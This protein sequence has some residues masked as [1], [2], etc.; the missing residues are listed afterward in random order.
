[1]GVPP[2]PRPNTPHPPYKRFFVSEGGV[3]RISGDV[4]FPAPTPPPAPNPTLPPSSP[5]LSTPPSPP[6]HLTPPHPT[7]LQPLSSYQEEILG[8]RVSVDVPFPPTLYAGPLEFR[9]GGGLPTVRHTND[10]GSWR[11]HPSWSQEFDPDHNKASPKQNA[12]VG[13]RATIGVRTF[14]PCFCLSP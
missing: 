8:F 13:P 6:T 4:Y 3:I 11:L 14:W 2:S 5:P 1:M 12:L 7:S 10:D 9:N